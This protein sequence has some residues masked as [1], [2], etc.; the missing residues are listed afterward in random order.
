MLGPGQACTS[1]SQCL[2]NLFCA[3]GVCCNA[4][5]NGPNQS[6]V[7]PGH[8]GVCIGPQPVPAIS[9]EGLAAGV[10]LLTVLAWL[11]LRTRRRRD[12]SDS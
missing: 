6:C 5:C 8:V 10:G 9:W 3:D 2:G 1:S 4:P 12:T 11:G 7:V